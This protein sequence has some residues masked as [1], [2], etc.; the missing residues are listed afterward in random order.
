M[1]AGYN[2]ISTPKTESRHINPRSRRRQRQKDR[3]NKS[4]ITAASTKNAKLF[5]TKAE[6]LQFTC[7]IHE[8]YD[9]KS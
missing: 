4:D 6:K 8:N 3:N 2:V 5:S 1:M 9:L 7:L